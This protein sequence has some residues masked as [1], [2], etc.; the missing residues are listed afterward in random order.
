[1]PRDDQAFVADVATSNE[2]LCAALEENLEFVDL[3]YSEDEINARLMRFAHYRGYFETLG[4]ISGGTEPVIDAFEARIARSLAVYEHD[5]N[6]GPTEVIKGKLEDWTGPYG[7]ASYRF[8]HDYLPSL[9]L[10]M[11]TKRSTMQSMS[12]IM[13][14]HQ[15][16]IDQARQKYLDLLDNTA[17]A[18][19]ANARA[20]QR[21]SSAASLVVSIVA[22]FGTAAT[23]AALPGAPVVMGV[24]F[25]AIQGVGSVIDHAS[26]EPAGDD[27]REITADAIEK[28]G[29]IVSFV[30]EET[31]QVETG[32]DRVLEYVTGEYRHEFLAPE[33][34]PAP[35]EDVTP[36][37]R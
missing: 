19:D 17:R 6:N 36:V 9:A 14:T 20:R 22:A 27:W 15:A 18:L 23:I 1:M 25:G 4:K 5:N 10:A 13:T 12:M 3:A 31:R 21:E 26:T 37:E 7:S 34:H 35:V 29:D 16:I 8:K 32:L 28:L 24:V 30:E 2:A 33:V 11:A